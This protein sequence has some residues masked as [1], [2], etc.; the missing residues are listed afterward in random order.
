M[1]KIIS[2]DKNSSVKSLEISKEAYLLA[3]KNGFKI[4][5]DPYRLKTFHATYSHLIRKKPNSK[6]Y[7]INNYRGNFRS[8]NGKYILNGRI[9]NPGTANLYMFLPHLAFEKDL[10]LITPPLDKNWIDYL[11]NIGI[12][13]RNSDVYNRTITVNLPKMN[14]SPIEVLVK[15]GVYKQI[16]YKSLLITNFND[17]L[18]KNMVQ[19]REL[20]HNQ[21]RINSYEGNSK[22][23]QRKALLPMAPSIVVHNRAEA[24]E[25][26]Q[27]FLSLGIKKVWVKCGNN[28]GAG[29]FMHVVALDDSDQFSRNIANVAANIHEEQCKL[30]NKKDYKRDDYTNAEIMVE[31]DIKK[32]GRVLL[33]GSIHLIS[34]TDDKITICHYASQIKDTI[35]SSKA[36]G[37]M[38]FL[39]D[40]ESLEL[41]FPSLMQQLAIHVAVRQRKRNY[42]GLIGIDLFIVEMTK[43]EHKYYV[44]LLE[45]VGLLPERV[46]IKYYKDKLIVAILGEINERETIVPSIKRI[47]LNL[48][49]KSYISTTLSDL[50]EGFDF[51][52]L[53]EL[54]K[55]SR[56][57]IS[58]VIPLTR[59]PAGIDKGVPY[60]NGINTS[61]YV[62]IFSKGYDV[63]KKYKRLMREV[64]KIKSRYKFY[65]NK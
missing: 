2:G 39:P 15:N 29:Q 64:E 42:F 22:I 16:P 37:G 50:P 63:K 46:P 40:Q 10:I 61:F 33:E 3:K 18:T 12:Y 57:D 27:K 60:Y 35:D 7:L 13:T 58:E 55:K 59:K 26:G 32:L 25:A 38:N 19:E 47:A 4:D 31:A 52:D 34:N 43:K 41:F 20:V 49:Y 11:V 62:G 6:I 54:V 24:I 21:N 8:S 45:K 28:V 9:G 65:E 53:K 5:Y 23:D 44:Y 36:V 14:S 1:N 17:A 30:M 56:I 48:N 51:V